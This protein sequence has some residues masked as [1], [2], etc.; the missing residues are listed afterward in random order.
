M[1][2]EFLEDRKNAL[3]KA[4][5]TEQ[6]QQA[7][8]RIREKSAAK[9]RRAALAEAS[10]ITDESVLTAL[11]AAGIS[12]ETLTALSLIPLV[13]VAWADG[14]MDEGE[15]AAI[16]KASAQTH[17]DGEAQTLLEGWLT[18]PPEASLIETWKNYIQ[19][20]QSN[21]STA[22][23]HILRDRL[24]GGAREVAEA[25]GGFLGFGNKV[26]GEEAAVL[27]ELAACFES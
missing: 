4:F 22:D 3:E 16:Q 8:E 17:Q 21:L 15:R 14:T 2:S 1:S 20:L 12:V 25:A 10:G 19:A 24:I 6:N 23:R 9:V 13:A 26:S 18:A 27:D 5:F 7:L 11:D